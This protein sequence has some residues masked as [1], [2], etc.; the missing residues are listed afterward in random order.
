MLALLWELVSALLWGHWTIPRKHSTGVLPFICIVEKWGCHIIAA[1]LRLVS[2]GRFAPRDAVLICIYSKLH[3]I[4]GSPC[5][6]Y[7]VGRRVSKDTVRW[8]HYG[9]G[10]RVIIVTHSAFAAGDRGHTF[11]TECS[12]NYSG[13]NRQ[14]SPSIRGVRKGSLPFQWQR[15]VLSESAAAS[16]R[17]IKNREEWLTS[18]VASV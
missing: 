13:D 3:L 2:C 11:A 7:D 8:V 12:C 14:Q 1:D 5:P 9:K 16:S 15:K 4:S 18:S 10:W 6:S 17:G